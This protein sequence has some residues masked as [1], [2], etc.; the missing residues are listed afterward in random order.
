MLNGYLTEP[1]D[2]VNPLYK[3][4]NIH[5]PDITK[6]TWQTNPYIIDINFILKFVGSKIFLKFII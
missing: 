6:V 3:T 1:N 2:T 5:N 4:Q